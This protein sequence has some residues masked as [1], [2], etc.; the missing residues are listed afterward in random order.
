MLL[1][2]CSAQGAGTNHS[3]PHFSGQAPGEAQSILR[4]F[5]GPVT[6]VDSKKMTLT[7]KADDGDHTFKVTPKTKYTHGDKSASLKDAAVGKTVE[8]VVNLRA[9]S[10]TAI[11]VNIKDK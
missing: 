8:V 6:A 3:Q 1:T 4:M 7:I 11:T 2:S 9:Q 10:D 5:K